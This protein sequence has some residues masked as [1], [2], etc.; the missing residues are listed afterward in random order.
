LAPELGLAEL[1]AVLEP[2]LLQAASTS[3][4]A[5]PP[6]VMATASSRPGR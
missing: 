6:A 3:A 1:D 5:I 2:P 4:A